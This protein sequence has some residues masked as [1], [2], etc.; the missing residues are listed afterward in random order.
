M[1]S[2]CFEYG[3]QIKFFNNFLYIL[4][5]SNRLTKTMTTYSHNFDSCVMHKSV[6]EVQIN[7][8][9]SENKLTL[10]KFAVMW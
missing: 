5:G 2:V 7:V 1:F 9:V 4:C 3:T 10:T 6:T 8:L